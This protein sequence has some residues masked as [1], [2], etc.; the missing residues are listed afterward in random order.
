MKFNEELVEWSSKQETHHVCT[1]E[2]KRYKF[3]KISTYV[4]EI[5]IDER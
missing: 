3:M 1:D 4:R 2:E 5:E